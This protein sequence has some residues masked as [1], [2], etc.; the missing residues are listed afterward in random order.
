MVTGGA[1]DDQIFGGAGDDEIDGND[2]EDKISG[3]PGTDACANGV[4]S[5]CEEIIP[6]NEVPD[7]ADNDA[8]GTFDQID[9]CLNVVNPDQRDTDAD[10]FGNLCDADLDNSG[11]V[12]S[13][14][15]VLFNQ[16]LESKDRDADLDGNGIVDSIDLSLFEELLGKAPGPS[17]AE[18]E[19]S[20]VLAPPPAKETTIFRLDEPRV[21]GNNAVIM[22]N[23]EG[24]SGL[25]PVIPI[26]FDGKTIALNDAGLLP[27]EEAD[28]KKFSAFFR[29]DFEQQVKNEEDF[30]KRMALTEATEVSE[31][32]GRDLIET[33]PLVIESSNNARAQGLA[34]PRPPI[35]LK[36][37]SLL[38]EVVPKFDKIPTLPVAHDE[39]RSLMVTD[40]GVIAD[41]SRT[42]DICDI[43]GDSVQGNVN[44]VWSFK[45]LISNM[46]SG[47]SISAQQF[48]HNWLQQWMSDQTV[49]S[50]TIPART[51]I[52]NFFPSWDGVNASTLNMNQLPF[53]LLAIVNRIDLSKPGGYMKSSNP[54][55][56]RFVFG[57]V[58]PNSPSCSSGNRGSARQ[59]T[60]IF[61]Y[62]DVNGQCIALKNRANQWIALSSLTLGSSEYNTALQDIT[63]D[64]TLANAVPEKPNGSAL[65]QL[66]TNEIA[67][68]GFGSDWQLREFVIDTE[69]GN[70]GSTTIKQTPDPDL[71]RDGSAVTARYMEQNAD[72]IL[73]ETHVV[74]EP[75]KNQPFLGSHADY[76]TGEIWRAPT[77][78]TNFN[79]P[80]QLFCHQTN[81]SLGTPTVQGELRHKLSLNTCDDCHSGETDTSFTHVKPGS[82][83]TKLSG[84]LTGV[85]V[86]D[87][88][89]EPV[90]REFNDLLRRGQIL[91]D[92]AVK[93][94]GPLSIPGPIDPIVR[95]P[96][97]P[98]EFTVAN[99][100]PVTPAKFLQVV[101]F[102]RRQQSHTFPH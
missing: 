97:I 51:N 102:S 35:E 83:P 8:D 87:P 70:L 4:I 64:V 50:F 48:T 11:F 41:Q 33:K 30:E 45:T 16:R 49:N 90:E 21:N 15:L 74:R 63:N 13:V 25:K 96:V 6:N 68:G 23:F 78:P 59:M 101:P 75:F 85:T 37:G 17:N 20:F 54:G 94:C 84:F 32:S 44:G 28:D 55:E 99:E 5:Q 19:P 91:E 26:N 80:F 9:N 98:Q 72:R 67:L 61:E 39:M 89:G 66:R 18:A 47:G 58:D 56:I 73:C 76:G 82:F 86:F 79:I 40:A 69:N 60:V 52:Q 38:T 31:F 27:D 81:I 43:D 36:D 34:R 92:Q 53:R 62:G 93:S 29:F 10:G 22:V 7:Q 77:N 46:A 71:F 57:L 14:D 42:F 100:L 95:F 2:G 88:G 12:D 65:N 24:V 1:G 3:G